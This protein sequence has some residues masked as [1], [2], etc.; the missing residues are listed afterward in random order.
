MLRT[1]TEH[2]II[3]KTIQRQTLK[4]VRSAKAQFDRTV[5]NLCRQIKHVTIIKT[6]SNCSFENKYFYIIH[7][8]TQIPFHTAFTL[9]KNKLGSLKDIYYIN[10][11]SHKKQNVTYINEI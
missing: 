1:I 5:A 8:H 11:H 2:R 4:L 7:T 3:V 10:E 9:N 6:Y